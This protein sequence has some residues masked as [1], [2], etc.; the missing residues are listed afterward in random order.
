MT[1]KEEY[2]PQTWKVTM[3]S[4]TVLYNFEALLL[5]FFET[6]CFWLGNVMVLLRYMY[7]MSVFAS[8]FRFWLDHHISLSCPFLPSILPA[9]IV[10]FKQNVYCVFPLLTQLSSSVFLYLFFL[11]TLI[12]SFFLILVASPLSML[13]LSF[14][15]SF[16]PS[17]CSFLILFPIF[18]TKLYK[19]I[20]SS[21]NNQL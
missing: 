21:A 17:F 1:Q 5:L 6:L 9:F 12:L 8:D 15:P 10:L 20:N 18:I 3:Y 4:S 16:A 7:L 2:K 11:P 19:I 14:N 13:F